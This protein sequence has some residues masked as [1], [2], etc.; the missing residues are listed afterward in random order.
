[1]REQGVAYLLWL[2]CCIG[3][4][5][6][7]RFYLDSFILGIVWLVTGGLFGIGQLVDLILIPGMVDGCNLK[8]NNQKQVVITTTAQPVMAQQPVYVQQPVI[9]QQPIVGYVPPQAYVQQTVQTTTVQQQ[10]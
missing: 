8:Y 4:F 1:M 10:Y 9:V 5:G 3:L 6:L 2:G 7:H